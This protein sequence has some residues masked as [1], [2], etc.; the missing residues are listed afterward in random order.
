[1]VD[2]TT[3]NYGW[4]KPTVGADSNTWGGLLNGDMD[5]IDAD[6]FAVSGVANAALPKA[7]G[8]ITGSLTVDGGIAS[9]A[10]VT[11]QRSG[12]PTEGLIF[13]GNAGTNY[14]FYNGTDFLFFGAGTLSAPSGGFS[15]NLTGNVSGS[16]GS[17][18]G[19]AATATTAT[20]ATTAGTCTGN[21]A[22]ATRATSAANADGLADGAGTQVRYDPAFSHW[23]H[24]VGG[25][26]IVALDAINGITVLV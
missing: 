15:G 14:L 20:N 9:T 11:V 13:F 17:C 26:D 19:N 23:V 22:T 1:M 12:L 5:S 24:S 8:T 16:S 10:D 3:T 2:A 4:T 6:L 21:A 7:G 25:T 18:T